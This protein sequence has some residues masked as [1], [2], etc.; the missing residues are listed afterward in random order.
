M[1]VKYNPALSN[2]YA[3]FRIRYIMLGVPYVDCSLLECTH[4]VKVILLN[5]VV[6]GDSNTNWSYSKVKIALKYLSV[7]TTQLK[8]NKM[9]KRS[10]KIITS[11]SAPN[12]LYICKQNFLGGNEL[13]SDIKSSFRESSS[14]YS[15]PHG[16]L[17]TRINMDE[18]G[19]KKPLLKFST[20]N[21]TTKLTPAST[22][23]FN[24]KSTFL[25]LTVI[26]IL[27][28][29]PYVYS[30]FI[31]EAAKKSGGISD[32]ILAHLNVSHFLIGL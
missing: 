25:V 12:L 4:S 15:V 16:T 3:L 27:I 17:C 8:Q 26:G 30:S 14:K 6:F 9:S 31:V 1:G 2:K 19:D 28:T 22:I 7:T 5:S 21:Y 24:N 11:K 29:A 32:N 13:P 18:Y 23:I 10:P 20:G